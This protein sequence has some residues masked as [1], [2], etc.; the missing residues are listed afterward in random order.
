MLAARSREFRSATKRLSGRPAQALE[1]P[2]RRLGRLIPA[3]G[4]RLPI[5]RTPP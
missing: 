4:P 1:R 2:A 3:G 5:P